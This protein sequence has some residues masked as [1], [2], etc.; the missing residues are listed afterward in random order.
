MSTK[1]A[2]QA[3]DREQS[4]QAHRSRTNDPQH[5]RNAET[6]IGEFADTQSPFDIGSN[7]I[8]D[9]GLITQQPAVKPFWDKSAIIAVSLAM[10]TGALIGVPVG[11]YLHR[12]LS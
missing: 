1:R 6:P 10:L 9:D 7:S 8:R 4:R 3:K 11:R 2:M 12:L 5:P